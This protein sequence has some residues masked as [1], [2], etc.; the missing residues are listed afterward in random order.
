MV[1][2][3]GSVKKQDLQADS[4]YTGKEQDKII[5]KNEINSRVHKKGSRNKPLNEL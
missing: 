1:E 2:D 4:A 3:E 5:E